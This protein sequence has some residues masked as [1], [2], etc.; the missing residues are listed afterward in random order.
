MFLVN[1]NLSKKIKVLSRY[2]MLCQ[3]PSYFNEIEKT[4]KILVKLQCKFHLPV[5]KWGRCLPV[6]LFLN[7][8]KKIFLKNLFLPHFPSKKE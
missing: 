5:E 6:F 7:S 2:I 1:K 8:L 4:D 3:V